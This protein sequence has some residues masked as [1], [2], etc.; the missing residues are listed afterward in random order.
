[1]NLGRG[2]MGELDGMATL[3]F[4]GGDPVNMT[5]PTGLATE[6]TVLDAEVIN[7]V[8]MVRHRTMEWTWPNRGFKKE[9]PGSRTGWEKAGEDDWYWFQKSSDG[10]WNSVDVGITAYRKVAADAPEQAKDF[11]VFMGAQYALGIGLAAAPAVIP[12]V[13]KTAP[14]LLKGETARRIYKGAAATLTYRAVTEMAGQ[15]P[16]R[17]GDIGSFSGGFLGGYPGVVA[18]A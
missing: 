10:S 12:T 17:G 2:I 16:S 9:V 6:I 5:D 18:Y 8:P 1:M 13:L 4:C 3:T 7:G 11:A 14:G 15:E